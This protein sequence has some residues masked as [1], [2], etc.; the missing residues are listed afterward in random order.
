M[1]YEVNNRFVFYENFILELLS[2]NEDNS[3]VLPMRRLTIGPRYEKKPSTIDCIDG[4][5]VEA[6][7]SLD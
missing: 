7:L 3:H 5:C 1:G 2:D 4:L 6:Y